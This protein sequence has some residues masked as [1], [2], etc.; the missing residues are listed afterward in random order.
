MS[1][2]VNRKYMGEQAI[3]EQISREKKPQ[4]QFR[5]D[6][7][8]LARIA[9]DQIVV[10]GRV[11]GE[12]LEINNGDQVCCINGT[13]GV[14]I[15]IS[16]TYEG[17]NQRGL[18]VRTRK[19]L[20][21]VFDDNGVV[22]R[23]ISDFK[24][25]NLYKDAQDDPIIFDTSNLENKIA[26]AESLEGKV[27][28]V[29]KVTL[30]EGSVLFG[31]YLGFHITDRSV[32]LW[33]DTGK[34][35][36]VGDKRITLVRQEEKHSGLS[37]NGAG[38][39][40]RAKVKQVEYPNTA[41]AARINSLAEVQNNCVM[42]SGNLFSGQQVQIGDEVLCVSAETG[43]VAG[44]GK[45]LGFSEGGYH[46]GK[47]KVNDS[48]V[49]LR[50]IDKEKYPPSAYEADHTQREIDFY[51]FNKRD[52]E[53]NERQLAKVEEFSGELYVVDP[54]DNRSKFVGK[55]IGY[56]TNDEQRSVLWFDNG[57][58]VTVNDR[59]V[60]LHPATEK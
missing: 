33:L 37:N 19:E 44:V 7:V 43:K 39:V 13:T 12:L 1:R 3:L 41:L 56:H 46:I 15:V 40:G 59:D 29:F 11:G 16:G 49:I 24:S 35:V 14:P 21:T 25:P 36:E 34:C 27:G 23:K 31:R 6:L 26:T 10:S 9:G 2:R 28:E 22:V 55:Y 50:K 30:G 57:M 45:Y 42:V 8:K 38:F 53:A 54:G 51:P 52:P 60:L 18:L 20:K 58:C 17:R 48:S 4:P 32:V 47:R 5:E